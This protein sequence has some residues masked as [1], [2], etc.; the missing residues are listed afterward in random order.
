[1]IHPYLP[2]TCRALVLILIAAER[3]VV[4]SLLATE[5]LLASLLLRSM[6]VVSD[7]A[8]KRVDSGEQP[9]GDCP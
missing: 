5:A 4:G 8:K 6:V 1:M 3:L 9:D 2:L 7:L